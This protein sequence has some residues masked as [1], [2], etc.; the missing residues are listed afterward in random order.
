MLCLSGRGLRRTVSDNRRQHKE[1]TGKEVQTNPPKNPLTL[2]RPSTRS[3]TNIPICTVRPRHLKKELSNG[4]GLCCP[5]W[6]LKERQP[7]LRSFWCSYTFTTAG[8][9][10]S[11]LLKKLCDEQC[12]R[13]I[14]GWP[15]EGFLQTRKAQTFRLCFLWC[16]A[17][18]FYVLE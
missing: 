16:T 9:A 2:L 8:C 15:F 13:P 1:S 4:P 7:Q 12:I 3:V 18:V 6:P 5:V 11:N 14:P 10:K 17:E